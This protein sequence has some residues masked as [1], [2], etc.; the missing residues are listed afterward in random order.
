MIA[1]DIVIN[2]G[3]DNTISG[4]FSISGPFLTI[5]GPFSGA[6]DEVPVQSRGELQRMKNIINRIK[7]DIN[8]VS[9]SS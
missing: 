2:I 6:N 3:H 1:T 7:Q 9:V 4:P 8:V 5:S